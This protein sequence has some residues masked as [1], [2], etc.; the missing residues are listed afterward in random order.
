MLR[1]TRPPSGGWTPGTLAE[2]L[3]KIFLFSICLMFSFPL[4]PHPS[5]EPKQSHHSLLVLTAARFLCKPAAILT[6]YGLVPRGEAPGRPSASPSR[7][8]AD[9]PRDVPSRTLNGSTFLKALPPQNQ[10]PASREQVGATPKGHSSALSARTPSCPMQ[11]CWARPRKQ[12]SEEGWMAGCV[13]RKQS[14]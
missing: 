13:I 3:C 14:Q 5:E 7:A 8:S 12:H 2:V 9:H 10:S 6:S 4:T 11:G 1:H